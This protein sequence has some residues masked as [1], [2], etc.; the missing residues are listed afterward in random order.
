[1][2]MELSWW[3]VIARVHPVHLTNAD[4]APGGRQHSDK[5]IDSGC[6]SA[7][8]WQLPSTSNVTIIITQPI[9][10]YSF[11]RPTEGGRLS[12]PRHC[13][14]GTQPVPKAVYR[15]SCRDKYNCPRCDSNL[16]RFTPQSEALTTRRSYSC[17]HKWI[18]KKTV[19]E[20]ITLSIFQTKQLHIGRWPR[21]L[22]LSSSTIAFWACWKTK[23][24]KLSCCSA[25]HMYLTW[26]EWRNSA[27]FTY[28][29][30]YNQN[31]HDQTRLWMFAPDF[32][33]KTQY[34][35]TTT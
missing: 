30:S 12:R 35:S 34:G 8:S 23:I 3:L 15:T 1:M 28:I 19:M 22:S 31:K 2:F 14:K 18:N 25:Y 10:W 29:N 7:E 17:V 20:Q 11:Y 9:S 21:P 13:S 24:L 6:E 32:V 4:W 5:A 33:A 26:Q 27:K 16:G